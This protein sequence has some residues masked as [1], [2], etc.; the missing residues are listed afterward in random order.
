MASDFEMTFGGGLDPVTAALII[1]LY[2]LGMISGDD[3]EAM[4]RRLPEADAMSLRV[5]IVEAA[6]D[7]SPKAMRAGMHVIEGGNE[8][9]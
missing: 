9:D 8:A 2:Q 3:I 5:L 4:A 7:D 6:I 1:R